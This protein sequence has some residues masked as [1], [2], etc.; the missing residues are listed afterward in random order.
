MVIY[1]I[2]IISSLLLSFLC[3]F[4]FVIKKNQGEKVL[5]GKNIYL[6]V[7][8][9]LMT[10]IMSLR[11]LNVGIDTPTYARIFA[12]INNQSSFYNAI[13]KI[14]ISAPL[15]VL[16]CR[17]I[18]HF[19]TSPYCLITFSS[20]FINFFLSLYIKRASNNYPISIFLWFGLALFYFSMNGTRQTMSIV[21]VLNSIY[22]LNRN[23]KSVN[24][25]IYYIS[26]VLIHYS[27]LFSLLGIG[28]IIVTK[29]LKSRLNVISI[30]F[31]YSIIVAASTSLL[32][33]VINFFPKYAQYVNGSSYY[34]ILNGNGRG[35][36]ILLYIF[37]AL[38]NVFYI[39]L[40]LKEKKD[41]KICSDNSNY[42]DVIL[43]ILIFATIFGIVNFRN[44]LISRL[45]LFYLSFYISFIPNIY[46]VHKVSAKDKMLVMTFFVVVIG[47]YG[48]L[49]LIEN[50]NGIIPYSFFFN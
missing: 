48:F 20:I 49:T 29:N 18:G 30:S 7:M 41:T 25:W 3:K 45:L 44:E 13:N 40:Y 28:L 39:F 17:I 27:A 8:F 37:L 5:H 35:R 10:L 26:A 47:I 34:S 4:N 42:N 11:S 14:T 46:T 6:F 12:A 31:V 33:Y 32:R 38:I 2:L 43:P 15:Y 24:G 21:L 50:K 16:L 19:S 1:I 22:F 9:V 36:I 23:I